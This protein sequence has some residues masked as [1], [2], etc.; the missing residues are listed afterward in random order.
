MQDFKIARGLAMDHLKDEA[1]RIATFNPYAAVR[2]ERPKVRLRL[3]STGWYRLNFSMLHH[4]GMHD[5]WV[6]P[7]KSAEIAYKAHDLWY[8]HSF[9]ID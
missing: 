2:K 9:V 7:F 5:Y 8:R 6:G 3:H 4:D 1:S